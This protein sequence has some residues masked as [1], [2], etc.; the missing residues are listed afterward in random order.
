MKKLIPLLLLVPFVAM[1]G[2]HK[3]HP[4]K[5]AE[6]EGSYMEKMKK[7]HA[8]KPAKEHAGKPAK[9]HAGKPAKEHGGKPAKKKEHAGQPMR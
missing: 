4:G 3:E 7:E 6:G 1:A 5:S 8:G 2:G 9:E